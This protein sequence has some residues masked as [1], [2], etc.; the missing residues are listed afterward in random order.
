MNPHT[1]DR[2]IY[3]KNGSEGGYVVVPERSLD[4][5]QVSFVKES[6]IGGRLEIDSANL[7]I[8]RVFLWSD[9]EVG[10][11]AAQFAINLVADVGG[12]R[13]HSR[14]YRYAQGDGRARQQ[15]APLLPPK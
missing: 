2:N 14:R 9:Y 7:K 3:R 12:D 6:A 10:A 15:L 11:D 1:F 5:W 4:F 13:N 8:E